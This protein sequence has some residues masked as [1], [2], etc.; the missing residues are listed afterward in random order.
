MQG[1]RADACGDPHSL[2]PREKVAARCAAARARNKEIA[3]QLCISEGTVKLHLFSRLSQI[4]VTNR[5]GLA[6]ALG[7]LGSKP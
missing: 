6:L 7:G 2:S 5:V 1:L 3:S 4:A